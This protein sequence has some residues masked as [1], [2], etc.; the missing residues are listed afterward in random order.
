MKIAITHPNLKSILAKD[1]SPV[2]L[3]DLNAG[4]ENASCSSIHLA[5]C[6]DYVP[7]SE[8]SKV[9]ATA[10]KKLRYGGD[11]S[12]SG[13]DLIAVCQHMSSGVMSIIQ[14]NAS[15]FEGRLSA[16]TITDVLETLKEMGLEIVNAKIEGMYYSIKA[17]RPNV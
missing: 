7:P 2:S 1:E 15:L 5:D 3:Q 8:R 9:L 6:M 11:I 14:A 13:T 12:I 10:L 16:S 4:V 17:R